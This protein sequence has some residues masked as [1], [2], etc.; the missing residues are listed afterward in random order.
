MPAEHD[1]RWEPAKCAGGDEGGD[2]WQGSWES[3]LSSLTALCSCLNLKMNRC[4]VATVLLERHTS[5]CMYKQHSSEYSL[6]LL[7]SFLGMFYLLYLP[8]L[9]CTRPRSGLLSLKI[10]LNHRHSPASTLQRLLHHLSHHAYV[11]PG[12]TVKRTII[13][14]NTLLLLKLCSRFLSCV[15][16][17]D[18]KNVAGCWEDITSC[19]CFAP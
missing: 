14:N 15:C 3:P 13:K 4:S 9:I 10:P 7:Y 8:A 17:E 5:T 16:I 18:V 12:L 6:F 1:G 19:C 11:E 2:T